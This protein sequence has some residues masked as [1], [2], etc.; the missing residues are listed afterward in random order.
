MEGLSSG[1]D[2]AREEGALSRIIQVP[3]KVRSQ[4]R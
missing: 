3:M 4:V 2:V 1:L